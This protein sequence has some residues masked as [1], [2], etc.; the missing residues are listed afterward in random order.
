[1]DDKLTREQVKKLTIV[2]M[3]ERRVPR[4]CANCS[5][6]MRGET[7]CTVRGNRTAAFMT[8]GSHEYEVE[9]LVNKSMKIL[10][11][12]Q[13]EADKVGNLLALAITTANTTTL[14]LADLERRIKK[15]RSG[16]TEKESRNLLKK[17]LNLAEDMK[18]AFVRI[19]DILGEMQEVMQEKLAKIDREYEY[20]VQP[21]I[22]RVFRSKGKIDA[23]RSDG[24]LNNSFEFGRLLVKFTKK[25]IYNE[26][27]ENAIFDFIDS[28]HNDYDYALDEKDAEHYRLKGYG[29]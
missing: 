3:E 20:H 8:C 22:D 4:M 25:A 10:E 29:K 19:Q 6:W 5:K 16:E 11:E 2:Q 24:H 1:M 15:I 23:D 13:L 21:Y 27:N 9:N 26:E 12:Q 28:L 17:D 14:F 18:G 7:I